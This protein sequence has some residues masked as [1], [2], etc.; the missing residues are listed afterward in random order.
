MRLTAV[1]L[2]LVLAT[3][4]RAQPSVDEI[5][6][7]DW[8]DA[9]TAEIEALVERTVNVNSGTMNHEGVRAVGAILRGELDGLGFETEWIDMPVE[10]DRAG[11]LFARRDGTE[12]KRLLLIGHLDTVFEPD[13]KFQDFV[14]DGSW[15]SGPGTVDMKS[16]NVIILYALKALVQIGALEGTQIVVA[17]SGDEESVGSPIKISRRDLVEASQWADVALGFEYGVRDEQAEWI[18]TA[19]RSSSGWRLEVT[20]RQAHSSLVFSDEVGAGAIFEAARILTAFYENVRGEQYL[21]FNAGT[22]LGGT[23]VEYDYG[24][25]RGETFGK[26]NIVP[27]HVVVH[28]G[29]RTISS[30]QLERARDSMR[31]VVEQHLPHTGAKIAFSDRYPAMPPTD[32]NMQLHTMLSSISEE[33]GGAPLP[34]LD[35][36]RRGAADISFV[37]P[38]ADALA[39]LGGQGENQ[40]SPEERLD[41]N[42]LSIAIKR[43]AVMV[44]RL[45]R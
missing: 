12:G 18:T 29:I 1:L 31:A 13:D 34:A 37:A 43:A 6:M 7:V 8:V 10:I 41:L 28:G 45:T 11:H 24:N 5:K 9:Q 39:G 26:T 15:A 4:A 20:G 25:T 40:H 19:R 32:G 17:Y 44:Y 22:I 36:S 21:T 30:E 23:D 14:R 2:L 16:G 33:L 27:R 42:S 35:P 3:T 38:Y